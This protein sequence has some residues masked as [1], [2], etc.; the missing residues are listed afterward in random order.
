MES[1]RPARTTYTEV[2]IQLFHSRQYQPALVATTKALKPP[3]ETVAILGDTLTLDY[4]MNAWNTIGLCYEYLNKP[5]SAFVAFDHAYAI[6]EKMD[7]PFW[8]GVIKGNKGD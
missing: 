5:D 3:V 7:Q 6:A 1:E 4:K 2:D 8:K